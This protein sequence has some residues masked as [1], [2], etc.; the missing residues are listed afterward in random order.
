RH[1]L[2]LN[3]KNYCKGLGYAK[4]KL[5]LG[6]GLLTS[7]GDYWR[8]QRR[9]AQPPFQPKSVAQFDG[10]MVSAAEEVAERW[11][12]P[13]GPAAGG[14]IDISFGMMRLTAIIIGRTMLSVDLGREA[15]T[16][17]RA[18]TDVFQYATDRTIAILD[19][20]LFIPTPT[21]RRFKRAL[22]MID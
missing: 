7:E 2:A 4:L 16:A 8:R 9:L 18:F 10:A 11:Q 14:G 1:V 13:N 20:P 3:S 5:F 17:G 19:I 6:T 15:A 21:N 12:S 22:Q